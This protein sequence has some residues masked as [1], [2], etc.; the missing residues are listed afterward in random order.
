MLASLAIEKTIMQGT[1]AEVN[2]DR[3]GRNQIHHIILDTLGTMAEPAEWRRT[4]IN[5]AETNLWSKA[6]AWCTLL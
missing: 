3:D 6:H 2:I 1:D 5:F 4:G